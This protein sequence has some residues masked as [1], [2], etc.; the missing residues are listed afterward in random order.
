M[1]QQKSSTLFKVSLPVPGSTKTRTV[2]T[3]KGMAAPR[4]NGIRRPRGLF[5]LSDCA[6]IKGSMKPSRSLPH[7]V[8]IPMTVSPANTAPWV[9]K[10]A[11]PRESMVSEGM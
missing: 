9:I 7:P 6:A 3:P 5:S 8:M 4:M 10:T 11:M 1:R 2:I